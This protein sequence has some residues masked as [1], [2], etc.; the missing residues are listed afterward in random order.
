MPFCP[1]A[2]SLDPGPTVAQGWFATPNDDDNNGWVHWGH[3][4]NGTGIE[5]DF[6]PEMASSIAWAGL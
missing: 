1:L 5:E 2:I 6:W 3:L 4:A